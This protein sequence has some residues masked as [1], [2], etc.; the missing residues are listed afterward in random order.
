MSAILNKCVL[1]G[2]EFILLTSMHPLNVPHVACVNKETRELFKK[3]TCQHVVFIVYKCFKQ[4]ISHLAHTLM[5][6][7]VK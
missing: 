5:T 7:K 4:F 6:G 2:E 3:S 1:T